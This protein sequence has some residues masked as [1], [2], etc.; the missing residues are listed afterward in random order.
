MIPHQ[1][2][3]WLDNKV[4]PQRI[5]ISGGK[6]AVDIALQIAGKLQNVS[7]EKIQ[8]GI[9]TDTLF[10]PD[11]GK[12]FKIDWSDTAK[13]E[14]QGEYENVRG[15]IRWAHQKPCEGEWR[16][17][18]LEGLERLSREAPHA[19]LKLIEEPPLKTIFLFTTRNHHHHRLLDTIISRLTLVRLP[20]Q[21]SQEEISSDIQTFF[22]SSNLIEKFK[23]IESLDKASKDNKDKKI[24]RQ[25]FFDFLN[26]SMNYARITPRYHN[27]L[28]QILETHEAMSQNI[29]PRFALER[30]ALKVAQ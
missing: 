24:N 7:P 2:Q 1:I 4:F 8:K 15:M 6:E 21:N 20:K 28:E 29:N 19:C 26:E 9:H 22:A 10:F 14:E 17:V 25:V 27:H 11:N 16:I 3:T 30:L 5:L 18:I 12:S 13:K 23:T